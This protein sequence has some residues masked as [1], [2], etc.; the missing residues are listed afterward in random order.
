MGALVTRVLAAVFFTMLVLTGNV[1]AQSVR[2]RTGELAILKTLGFT[3]GTVTRLV[4]AE[5]GLLLALGAAA[6]M[7][8][9]VALLPPLNAAMGGRFPPLFV[10]AETWTA[11]GAIAAALA[12]AVGVLPALRARRLRIVDALAGRR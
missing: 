2:E 5:A 9:A 11:G 4:L 6:G 12:L 3:D 10:S 1:M 8:S 7:G